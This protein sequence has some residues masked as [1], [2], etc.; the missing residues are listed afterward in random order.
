M[1]LLLAQEKAADAAVKAAD[2]PAGTN[3]W[4]IFWLIFAVMFL[5]YI[6]GSVIAKALRLKDF[7]SR[8]GTVLFCVAIAVVPMSY[9]LAQGKSLGDCFRLGIDL[10]GGTNLVYQVDMNAATESGKDVDRSIDNM[11][12]A[13]ARRVN[14]SGT[15]EV[16]VRRVGSDRIE[17]IIPGADQAYVDEMK[18]RITRLGSLQF[19]ILATPNNAEHRSL[20]KLANALSTEVN[21]VVEN[22]RTVAR[23]V[24]IAEGEEV[25]RGGGELLPSVHR[26]R[27][28]KADAEI[29][30]VLVVV[31]PEEKEVTGKF[32]VRA[33]EQMDQSGQLVVAFSFDQTGANRFLDLTSDHKPLKDG[34]RYRLAV[35]LDDKIQSAPSL[36]EAIGARGQISGNFTRE[37]IRSLTS[38]LNAGALDVPI[39]PDPISEFTISPLLGVDIRNKG[40]FAIELSCAVVIGFMAIY[41]LKAG[42]IAVLCLL[43]NILLIMGT[44]IFVQG[45]FTLPGLA[46]LV[47]TIGMAVDANVLIFER[48]RE[49]LARGASIRMAIHNGFDKAFTAIIDSN[50]TTL[51]VAIVLFMIGTDQVK[52]FAVTLFIGIVMSMFSALYFG[53]LVFEILEQKR[54]LKKLPML[55]IVKSPSLDFIGKQKLAIFSS[56][57]VICAGMAGFV[58]RGEDNLD[59]DFRG[60]TMVTFEFEEAHKL[61][62]FRSNLESEFDASITV[63]RLTLEGE[64]QES[65]SGRRWRLRTTVEKSK[66]V[67]AGVAKSLGDMG[68]RTVSVESTELVEIAAAAEPAEGEQ[69][70]PESS[71][72]AGGV[73]TTLTFSD[74]ITINT[75]SRNLEDAIKEL[76]GSTYG[77]PGDL[78]R[79]T[80]ISGSGIDAE[81]GQVKKFST[82]KLEASK[83]LKKEDLATALAAMQDEMNNSPLFEE[84]S[85][86]AKS[87]GGEMQNQAIVAMLISLG[88]IIIYVAFR[89]HRVT[90]GIAA[91]AA[92]V[93]DVL[94][95]LGIVA[96]ASLASGGAFGSLLGL[97]DFK[98][99]LPMIA[100]F[101][102]IVGYS[103]N[104]TIVVFDRIRE[105]RGKNPNL[106]PE[107]INTSLNQTLSRTL[108]T[109]LTTF[110]VVAILY[111][112]GG[113]GIHGFA[114]CL[115]VGVLVGTYSSIY[116]ASPVL[117]W[118]MNREEK[119]AKAA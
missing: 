27:K 68:L 33:N 78:F 65:D 52:G 107:M 21:P 91:V 111:I 95:V 54:F 73:E 96:L 8:I 118:L 28:G 77:S 39:V 79:V 112:F 3:G 76:S 94:V 14:P 53:R 47:L 103:L 25:G 46:G 58:S 115:L 42:L 70:D 24:D 69:V 88:A 84:V 106:T 114:F 92:L 29:E 85:N 59:I 17:I 75:A 2:A 110:F 26:M 82:V 5:P 34:K 37:E 43:L 101:L 22:G 63:E 6:L 9:Q 89:F 7:S 49:E 104:D 51:I 11:V 13:I 113:E 45:T 15:E 16:T 87:V 81:E 98:I 60:G 55:S 97:Y 56:L 83:E 117:L 90:F 1:F 19:E 57:F 99:N 61:A 71:A 67:E 40:I 23:W 109:S 10:A 62:D 48:I 64:T 72:F 50:L 44:M 80:G 100:A 41:Y 93:H 119:V 116:V 105:V 4:I 66:E 30:Q 86:F 74:E 32:L 12:G 31:S 20:I 38:V 108:L 102:T 36:N 18:D 35:L